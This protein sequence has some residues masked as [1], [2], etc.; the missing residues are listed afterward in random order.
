MIINLLICLL[1]ILC[2]TLVANVI[3]K[4]R[5]SILISNVFIVF[6]KINNIISRAETVDRLLDDDKGEYVA[7]GYLLEDEDYFEL[8]R[9]IE[10]LTEIE[11]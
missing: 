4:A 11:L 7:N 5:E 6:E 8:C 1:S 10:D 9:M 2:T 3:S